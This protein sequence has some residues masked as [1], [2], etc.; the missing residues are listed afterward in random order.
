VVSST[1]YYY[2]LPVYRIH[3]LHVFSSTNYHYMWLVP[4]TTTTNSLYTGHVL[5]VFSS[6]DY[7]YV[8]SSTDYYYI[9]DIVA[10]QIRLQT[11]CTH[12]SYIY[13]VPKHGV[14][15]SRIYMVYAS[16]C[17]TCVACV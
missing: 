12:T 16:V 17:A 8:F 13:G 4:Q 1:T 2:K 5:H 6:T 14:N 9:S 7:Y 10:K 3:V 15:I 11:P